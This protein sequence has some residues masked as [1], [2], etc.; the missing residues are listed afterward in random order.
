MRGV[1]IVW[2][3]LLVLLSVVIAA[4]SVFALEEKGT[5][6]R[7]RIETLE[8]EIEKAKKNL[9]NEE[10]KLNSQKQ[11]KQKVL[12]ELEHTEKQIQTLT[13]NLL[14]IKKE[15]RFLQQ[16]ITGARNNYDSASREIE[17]HSDRYATRLKSVY[18]RHNISPLDI[19]YSA[20]SFSSFLWGFK[21]LS[22]LA[23]EDMDMLETLR[24]QQDTIRVA[25]TTIK[26]ALDAKVA[27]ARTKQV[28]EMQLSSSQKKQKVLI[29]EIDKDIDLRNE[30]IQKVLQ[31]KKEAEALIQQIARQLEE[32]MKRKGVPPALKGY[33]FALRRGKL[34]WPVSGKV[35]T[36]FGIVIDRQTKTKVTS[37]GIEILTKYNEPVRS[38]GR[39]SVAMTNSIRGYG[40]FIII[41][42]PENYYTVYG[43][44]SDILVNTGDIVEE[45]ATIGTSGSTGLLDD[46]EAQ[47]KLE[48]LN[49]SEP[50]DP[51]VWL[52]QENWRLAE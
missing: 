16:E 21:M 2:I 20:G 12:R 37:R 10:K 28:E 38:V 13:R 45:G 50:E 51:L 14:S 44:L 4:G 30:K 22:V 31:D 48:V 52:R 24:A 9:E 3:R 49:G 35:V 29:A 23:E 11:E 8:K 43:H 39:G 41:Y 32:Q 1:F 36:R 40:N 25:I 33:N 17:E 47:L 7:K 34:P 18:K 42:H 5:D 26:A 19:V 15:E 6:L 46:S 27:L